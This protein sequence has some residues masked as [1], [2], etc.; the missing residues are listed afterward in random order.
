M[1]RF[2]FLPKSFQCGSWRDGIAPGKTYEADSRHAQILIRE[3]GL[4]DAKTVKTPGVSQKTS[5]SPALSSERTSRYRSLTMRANYLAMVRPDYSAKELAWGMSKPTEDDWSSNG[6]LDTS[7][8]G[9]G[10]CGH[11]INKMSRVNSKC[12]C[13]GSP[14]WV[15]I[16]QEGSGDLQEGHPSVMKGASPSGKHPLKVP[17][18]PSE[19]FKGAFTFGRGGLKGASRGL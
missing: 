12:F 17:S 10:W 13:R 8:V 9:P 4:Q 3:L 7:K 11:I 5:D 14:T 6:L 16:A 1:I 19:G 18:S 2:T 15:G